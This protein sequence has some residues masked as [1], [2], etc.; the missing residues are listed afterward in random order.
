MKEGEYFNQYD[1]PHDELKKIKGRL[2][3][4]QPKPHNKRR[5]KMWKREKH[6]FRPADNI[7]NLSIEGNEEMTIKKQRRKIRRTRK[8]MWRA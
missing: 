7:V 1:F 8:N 6:S 2:V 5:S 3:N 4:T